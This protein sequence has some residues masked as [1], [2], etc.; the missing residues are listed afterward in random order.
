MWFLVKH[1]F[2]QNTQLMLNSHMLLSGNSVAL[3][4]QIMNGE[5]R[6]TSSGFSIVVVLFLLLF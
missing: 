1:L 5:I 2:E 4:W 6:L 3:L